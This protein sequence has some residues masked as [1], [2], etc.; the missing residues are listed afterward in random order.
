[1]RLALDWGTGFIRLLVM[2]CPFAAHD[3][4]PYNSSEEDFVGLGFTE[5]QS[6]WKTSPLVTATTASF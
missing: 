1:M 3:V 6:L 4:F 2:F 5:A